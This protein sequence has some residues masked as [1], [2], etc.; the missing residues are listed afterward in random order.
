MDKM[1]L[2]LERNLFIV[3]NTVCIKGELRKI[4]VVDY[5]VGSPK[6]LASHTQGRIQRGCRG[7]QVPGLKSPLHPQDSWIPPEH[8]LQFFHHE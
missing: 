7:T 2:L 8:P 5:C 1:I 3:F 6:M 4:Q